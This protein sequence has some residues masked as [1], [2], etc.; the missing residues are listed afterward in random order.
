MRLLTVIKLM[1]IGS[2]MLG[3]EQTIDVDL[4]YERLIVMNAFV[5]RSID[6]LAWISKTLPATEEPTFDKAAIM[7]ADVKLFWRDTVYQLAPLASK[8]G[9][10]LPQP[11]ARWQGD[12]MRMAVEWDGMRAESVARMPIAPIVTK[13]EFKPHPSEPDFRSLSVTLRT[14][15]G[16]VIWLQYMQGF[17]EFNAADPPMSMFNYYRVV[18][19]NPNEAEV[20]ITIDFSDG[21]FGPRG[22]G[23]VNLL[24]CAADASYAKF[25]DEPN[26]NTDNPF[27]FG[28]AR[29]FTNVSGRGI[30]MFVP[31]VSVLASIAI[32]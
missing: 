25:L 3:C 23:T 20:T 24:V 21:F 9:F 8:R 31:V 13:A 30:G 17:D 18:P 11:D 32:E 15:P 12:S 16:C 1:I 26:R 27:S 2:F 4:P 7:N 10:I 5:G 19:G 29:A 14:R 28:G 22:G 6:S